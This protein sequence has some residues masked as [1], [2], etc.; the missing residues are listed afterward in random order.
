[1]V[2]AEKWAATPLDFIWNRLVVPTGAH[3]KDGALSPEL[4]AVV[5]RVLAT[6][7]PVVLVSQPAK[8]PALSW[9]TRVLGEHELRTSILSQTREPFRGVPRDRVVNI[10][11]EQLLPADG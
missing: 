3:K 11:V 8:R 9:T 7:R 5:D 4:V 10:L 1:L 2:L 6:G